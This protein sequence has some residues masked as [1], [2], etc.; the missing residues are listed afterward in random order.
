M[1]DEEAAPHIGAIGL[2][3]ILLVAWLMRPVEWVWRL[4]DAMRRV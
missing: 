2:A 3:V 4:S 1:T